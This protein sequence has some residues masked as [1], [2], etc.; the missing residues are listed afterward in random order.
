MSKKAR[1]VSPREL[2][3]QFADE[4]KRAAIL[5]EMQKAVTKEGS[6][7]E[8]NLSSVLQPLVASGEGVE[9]KDLLLWNG[10][11]K[12]KGTQIDNILVTQH[13]IYCFEVKNYRGKVFGETESPT[14][15][16][17]RPEG[18]YDFAYNPLQQ[19]AGHI[20][21]LLNAIR[22]VPDKPFLPFI[23]VVVFSDWCDLSGLDVGDSRQRVCN[24]RDVVDMVRDD[25]SSMRTSLSGDEVRQWA[26]FFDRKSDRTEEGRAKHMRLARIHKEKKELMRTGLSE[27]EAEEQ[28]KQLDVPTKTERNII[29]R[30]GANRYETIADVYRNALR[31]SDGNLPRRHVPPVSFIC[32]F[33]GREYHGDAE[34]QTFYDGMVAMYLSLDKDFAKEIVEKSRNGRYLSTG[35]PRYDRALNSFGNDPGKFIDNIRNSDWFRDAVKAQPTLDAAIS[36]AALVAA[37][38]RASL[39]SLISGAMLKA[40]AEAGHRRP[41]REAALALS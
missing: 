26:T 35:V 25:A 18:S 6:M 34:M 29:V 4:R 22:A 8:N 21:A 23:G 40:G 28:V 27:R 32:P 1:S 36:G 38:R 30:L 9:V 39:D 24:M 7:G 10:T 12:T 14:W 15:K 31:A 41:E 5:R 17:L 33:T 16:H 3:Q 19:N 13:G 37:N 2:R 20:S 11:D